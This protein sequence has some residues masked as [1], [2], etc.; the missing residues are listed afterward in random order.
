MPTK[1]YVRR[2][3]LSGIE[4]EPVSP[5]H[6]SDVMK[7]NLNGGKTKHWCTPIEVAMAATENR[8]GC[9]HSEQETERNAH[10][11]DS[12]QVEYD[13][14]DK[15]SGSSYDQTLLNN[16]F[17]QKIGCSAGQPDN[18]LPGNQ[19]FQETCR[20]EQTDY[21]ENNQSPQDRRN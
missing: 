9:V 8:N 5:E 4:A 2:N 6:Q 3:I 16:Q 7:P 11:Y 18:D 19:S 1:G 13:I 10:A 15:E 20:F 14:I 17:F 12:G 21:L